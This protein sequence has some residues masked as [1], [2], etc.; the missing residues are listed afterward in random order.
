M[1]DF[2]ALDESYSVWSHLRLFASNSIGLHA[3]GLPM[4]AAAT[5]K[6]RYQAN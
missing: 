2:T 6:V 1:E 4:H 3:C 5:L